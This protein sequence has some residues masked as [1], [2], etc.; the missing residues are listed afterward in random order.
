[1]IQ[2]HVETLEKK[3]KTEIK[4]AIATVKG[5]YLNDE[6]MTEGLKVPLYGVGGGS[7]LG[8]EG[9]GCVGFAAASTEYF[10][11]MLSRKVDK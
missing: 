10:E 6:S 7:G 8:A 3:V 1:M 2:S 4:K 9:A 5:S 11:S